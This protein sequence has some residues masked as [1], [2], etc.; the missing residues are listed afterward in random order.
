MIWV[1]GANGMLGSE[2]CEQLKKSKI[3]FIGTDKEIDITKSENI[4]NF[5]KMTNSKEY[6]KASSIKSDILKIK[7]II[8]C[9]AYTAVEKAEENQELA[10]Q[11]NAIAPKKIAQIAQ[12]NGIKLIHISTDYVFD[13]NSKF[14]LTEDMKKNPLG[15]YG[16]TKSQGEDFIQNSMT[17]YYIIRTAWLYGF[18]HP[19]FVYTMINLM[20]SKDEINVVND[21]IGCPTF[22]GDLAKVIISIIKKSNKNEKKFDTN[23]IIPYGIYNYTNMGEISW[24]DFATK[25]YELGKKYKRVLKPCKVLPCSSDEFNAK[26]KRPEYSVLSKNKISSTLKIKIPVWNKSLAKFLKSKK[27]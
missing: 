18:K 11:L 7:W 9:A 25:I 24:F 5:L 26:V 4:E 27:F 23:S 21:Q 8:N 13:G 19:N 3:P 2:V 22:A 1:I 10:Y 15:V 20:N 17:Q 14:P 12:Y 16:N 6:L